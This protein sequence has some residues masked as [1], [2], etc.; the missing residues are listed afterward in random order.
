MNFLDSAVP[1]FEFSTQNSDA[2]DRIDRCRTGL[3][4]LTS[5]RS[6]RIVT[7]QK[8][9]GALRSFDLV[10]SSALLRTPTDQPTNRPTDQLTAVLLKDVAGSVVRASKHEELQ[11]LSQP[12]RKPQSQALAQ[13]G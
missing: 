7:D 2:D 4:C 12:D 11:Q 1:G 9:R 3:N 8:T 5:A 10:I 13:N 6:H